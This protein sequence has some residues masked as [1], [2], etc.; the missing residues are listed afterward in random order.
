MSKE[1]REQINKVKNWKQFNENKKSVMKK[2]IGDYF[3][4]LA[5]ELKVVGDWV[6]SKHQIDEQIGTSDLFMNKVFNKPFEIGI[7]Q[8]K[9]DDRFTPPMLFAD[10][11]GMSGKALQERT[12]KIIKTDNPNIDLPMSWDDLLEQE[13]YLFGID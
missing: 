6:I 10:N 5:D 8:C 1:M 11:I 3:Y 2:Q 7:G 12:Y 4:W 13:D 9:L